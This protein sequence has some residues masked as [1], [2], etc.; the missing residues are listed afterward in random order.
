MALRGECHQNLSRI[1]LCWCGRR[2][3]GTRCEDILREVEVGPSHLCCCDK[4]F[5]G[6][7]EDN[8]REGCCMDDIYPL[9]HFAY[10]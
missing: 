6:A 5:C 2:L 7:L 4:P 1:T 3:L 10:L 8:G 9:C